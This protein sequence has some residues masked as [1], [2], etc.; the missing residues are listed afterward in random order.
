MAAHDARL[1]L[2]Y[3]NQLPLLP[4]LRIIIVTGLPPSNRP[5]QECLGLD[6]FDEMHL[7]TMY[8]QVA[9]ILCHYPHATRSSGDHISLRAAMQQA[10]TRAQ[11]VSGKLSPFDGRGSLPTVS[12]PGCPW[13]A[14]PPPCFQSS[15][16]KCVPN[17][18]LYKQV[19]AVLKVLR[20]IDLRRSRIYN[21]HVNCTVHTSLTAKVTHA[22][23]H[24]AT[25]FRP[26]SNRGQGVYEPTYV[27]HHQIQAASEGGRKS[28]REMTIKNR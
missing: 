6:G 13:I 10:A 26:F 25:N 1:G 27:T 18:P 7:R 12:R 11:T 4:V 16:D 9:I 28:R 17:Q 20:H 24:H 2:R 14:G 3:A 19:L 5:V 23:R 15:L 22:E 21:K 8:H